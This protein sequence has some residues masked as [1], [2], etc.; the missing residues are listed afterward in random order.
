M[1]DPVRATAHR[2]GARLRA[3]PL[4]GRVGHRG[5]ARRSCRPRRR[6]QRSRPSHWGRRGLPSSDRIRSDKATPRPPRSAIPIA[7]PGSFKRSRSGCPA[8]SKGTRRSFR[9]PTSRARF[10][11]RR[12]RTASTR[13]GS[14]ART[15]TGRTGTQ[16]SRCGNSPDGSFRHE[17]EAGERRAPA[18]CAA[19]PTKRSQDAC[20]HG[21]RP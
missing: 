11:A 15:R 9:R 12:P 6:R 1:L 8:A 7:T 10:G 17:A 21:R 13:S 19:D 16:I 3:E 2:R 14:A 4:P 5:G 20:S 18:G